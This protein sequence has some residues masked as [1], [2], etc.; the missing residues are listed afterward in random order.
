MDVISYVRP[1]SSV[2]VINFAR[3]VRG[4]IIVKVKETITVRPD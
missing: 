4:A 2:A 1:Q 3:R